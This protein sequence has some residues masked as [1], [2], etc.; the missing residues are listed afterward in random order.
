MI[1]AADVSYYQPQ[2]DDS[3]TRP[4][5]II[6]CCD[7]DFLDPKAIGNADW[8]RGA[9]AERRMLGWTA[10]V[11]YRPGK[12]AEILEHLTEIA[13][14]DR[15]MIDV[16]SWGGQIVGNH[17][18]EIN[19]LADSIGNAIG[20]ANV[21][22][23]GNRGD[24]ASIDPGNQRLTVVA[25]YGSTKPTLPNMIG[26]QYTNGQV[27]SGNRPLASAPFGA[28]DHNELYVDELSPQGG[29]IPIPDP[30]PAPVPLPI[31]EDDPMLWKQSL[32]F[33][34][35]GGDQGDLGAWVLVPDASSGYYVFGIQNDT[36]RALYTALGATKPEPGAGVPYDGVHNLSGPGLNQLL[37]AS[38]NFPYNNMAG[39]TLQPAPSSLAVPIDVDALAQALADKLAA[40]LPAAVVSALAN[41]LGA[42]S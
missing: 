14:L 6:R 36:E 34:V 22:V 42:T 39:K 15:V 35:G 10:Y 26:W 27:K 33:D 23:Y 12:N 29:G 8:C 2:A 31:P 20:Q 4:W 30:T 40:T 19:S 38:R 11:V 21:W 37:T 18:A 32:F 25:A 7:G 28:C 1:I 17:A 16:E 41:K 5:L 24:L 9:V 3:Y 13:P